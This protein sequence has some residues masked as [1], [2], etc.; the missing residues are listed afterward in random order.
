M[1]VIFLSAYPALHLG[2]LFW[3]PTPLRDVDRTGDILYRAVTVRER[4]RLRRFRQL[5]RHLIALPRHLKLGENIERRLELR[6]FGGS[7]A[8]LA[9]HQS[10]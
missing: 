10:P 9:G 8:L 6:P 7:I 4:S 2:R 5:G 3:Q 1:L